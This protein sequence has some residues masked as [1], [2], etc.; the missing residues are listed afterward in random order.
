MAERSNVPRQLVE[1]LATRPDQRSPEDVFEI[2][3]GL[4]LA[5]AIRQLDVA[6]RLVKLT[7]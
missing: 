3:N 6:T 2:S 5:S 1:L 7:E 4:F